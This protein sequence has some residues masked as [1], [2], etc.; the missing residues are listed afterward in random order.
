MAV[1]RIGHVSVRVTDIEKARDHYSNVI[2]LI[3]TH[4]ESGGTTYYKA[5]DEWDRYSVVLT[6]S[7]HSGANYI[8]YKVERD[9]ELD[10]FGDAIAKRGIEVEQLKPGAIPFV[11]R[12]IRFTL[13]S[14]HRMVLFAEK[15][16]VGRSVGAIN[17]DPWPDDVKG[18]GAMH[19]DHCL[20]MAEIEPSQGINRVADTCRFFTEVLNFQLTEQV[21][22]GPGNSIQAAAFLSCTSK[23]H[24]IAFVGGPRPGFHHFAFYLD[25]WNDVLR[26][27]DVLSKNRVKIDIG[28]TRH[29]ITR[30]ATIYFFDPAGNRNETFAGLGYFVTRDM[31]TITWT[32]E[33]LGAAIFYHGRELNP[34][35]TNVYTEAT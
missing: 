30:G 18:A 13:P 28:P 2:G 29:G 5:W 19:L 4:R 14:S 35:F 9:S 8:A 21:M 10:T 22:V 23:P 34:D 11:G 6:P 27:A 1:M 3:E 25:N 31:P 20:L 32:E 7:D 26:A 15:E 24:D 33:H 12:A 17:P 16:A